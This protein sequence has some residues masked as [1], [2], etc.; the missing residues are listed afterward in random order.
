V[1]AS[2]KLTAPRRKEKNDQKF[3]SSLLALQRKIISADSNF[4]HVK[5]RNSTDIHGRTLYP[6]PSLILLYKAAF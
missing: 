2:I 3:I 1:F 6:H 5:T 4:L